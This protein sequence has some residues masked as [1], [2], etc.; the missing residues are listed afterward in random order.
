MVSENTL[1][2]V[3]ISLLHLLYEATSKIEKFAMNL[4]KCIKSGLLRE[5]QF[6]LN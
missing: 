5:A 1:L 6:M 2:L 3:Y 4:V